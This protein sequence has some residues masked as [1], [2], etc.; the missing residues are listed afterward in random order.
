VNAGVSH[1]VRIRVQIPGEGPAS[2]H[3]VAH[4]FGEYGESYYDLHLRA[5]AWCKKN[6]LDPAYTWIDDLT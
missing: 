1:A 6:G 4:I 2:E 5:I 3:T